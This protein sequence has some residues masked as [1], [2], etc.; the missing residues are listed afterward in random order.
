MAEKSL[1]DQMRVNASPRYFANGLYEHEVIKA[2]RLARRQHLH[3]TTVDVLSFYSRL[4]AIPEVK[5]IANSVPLMQGQ[6]VFALYANEIQH[7]EFWEA[8][9]TFDPL[10]D[11]LKRQF[12]AVSGGLR[13]R[14]ATLLP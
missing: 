13:T 10:S 4:V 8:Y 9:R 5:A 6:V 1:Q 3:S 11:R 7:A 2:T 14:V 12:Q